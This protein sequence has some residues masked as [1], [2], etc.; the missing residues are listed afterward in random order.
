MTEITRRNVLA[1]GIVATATALGPFEGHSPANAAA[2]PVGKQAPGFYRY[3]IGTFEVTAVTD[4][5]RTDALP[6]TYVR[7]AKKEEV[8]A[9]L[10]AAHLEKDKLRPPFTPVVVNTGSKLVVIDTGLGPLLYEQSKGAVGQFQTNLAAAGIDRNAVDVVMISHFHGDHINGL[11]TAD[12]K[13]AFPNAE[14]MVP[15]VEWKYWT[16]EGNMSKASGTPLE[17]NFKNVRRVFGALN[18]KVTQYEA[19]KEP[20]PGITAMAT[21]GHTPG[22]VSYV[23]ASGSDRV[24]VQVD[25]TAHVALLFVRNP[26]W[27]LSGD[28]DGPM[29]E[30][31]RRKIYDMAS[32]ESMLIQGFHFPFPGLGYVE[33]DGAGYR[34]V[35][36]AWNPV[37]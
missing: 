14:I 19:G 31:T 20:V 18:N 23:V 29:A 28:M 16:D 27:H 8:N 7:N 35:P 9:A 37:P 36:A 3:K 5:M 33:K 32:A 4:G 12:S 21:Y 34:F 1:G 2:P 6:D 22:H 11:L 13:L 24:M 15:A 26:G 10:T 25:I 17:G 30:Q